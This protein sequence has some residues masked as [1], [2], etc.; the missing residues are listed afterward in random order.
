[1]G[2]FTGNEHSSSAALALKAYSSSFAVAPFVPTKPKFYLSVSH[3][4]TQ[5]KLVTYLPT[6]MAGVRG[7]EYNGKLHFDRNGHRIMQIGRGTRE[8]GA[9]HNILKAAEWDPTRWAATPDVIARQMGNNEPESAAY[10]LNGCYSGT[11]QDANGT[12]IVLQNDTNTPPRLSAYDQGYFDLSEKKKMAVLFGDSANYRPINPLNPSF[13]SSSA[14]WNMRENVPITVPNIFTARKNLQ[15]RKTY[16]G[17]DLGFGT[18]DSTLELW[19][20][21]SRIDEARAA[22]E[23]M[24]LIPGTGLPNQTPTQVQLTGG[25]AGDY[26]VIHGTQTNVGIGRARAVPIQGLRSDLWC[27]VDTR[28]DVG[29]EYSLFGI[30]LAGESGEYTINDQYMDPQNPHVPHIYVYVHDEKSA[31]Y[32]GVQP[33]SEFGDVGF[34]FLLNEGIWCLSPAR[35]EFNFIGAAS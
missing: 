24:T 20:A 8:W 15:L 32:Q 33:G 18:D 13:M 29:V 23:W 1:M 10:L 12:A 5:T 28:Q 30:A 14:W 34:T 3:V 35:I 16:M 9:A 4:E 31:L 27:L 25:G 17:D 7:R 22:L 11:P 26:Q 6:P 2:L 19:C 21:P